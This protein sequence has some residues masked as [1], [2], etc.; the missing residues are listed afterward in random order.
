MKVRSMVLLLS[1]MLLVSLVPASLALE[2]SQV[3]MEPPRLASINL[4]LW[5]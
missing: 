5:I 4:R 1:G 2:A 3:G